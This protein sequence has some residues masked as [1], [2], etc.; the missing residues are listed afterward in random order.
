MKEIYNMISN[1]IN[2]LRPKEIQI[3]L[4][5]ILASGVYDKKFIH[6]LSTVYLKFA[7]RE[8][9]KHVLRTAFNFA[10]CDMDNEVFW[11]KFFDTIKLNLLCLRTYMDGADD[12]DSLLGLYDQKTIS[13]LNTK[14]SF[15]LI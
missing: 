3:I 14:V 5:A 6:L 7:D 4:K 8:K 1:N 11:R 2:E 10:L 12:M 15:I 9:S 13:I